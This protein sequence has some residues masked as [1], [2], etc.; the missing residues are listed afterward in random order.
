MNSKSKKIIR[1]AVF[2][3]IYAAYESLI[4]ILDVLFLAILFAIPAFIGFKL[5]PYLGDVV[6]H[7]GLVIGVALM[8]IAF[9]HRKKHQEKL[10]IYFRERSYRTILR[11][12]K[13]KYLKEE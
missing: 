12:S 1:E 3:G 8:G 4:A 7:V 5:K 10:Q 11:V 13:N 6:G 2:I 9:V